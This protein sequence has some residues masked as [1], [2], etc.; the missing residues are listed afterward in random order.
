MTFTIVVFTLLVLI[1]PDLYTLKMIASVSRLNSNRRMKVIERTRSVLMNI[2]YYIPMFF[3]N[4]FILNIPC[5]RVRATQ[6]F[7]LF[8]R[9]LFIFF[10]NGIY[11][12]KLSFRCLAD[13]IQSH[14]IQKANRRTNHVPME[15]VFTSHC[16]V[17]RQIAWKRSSSLRMRNK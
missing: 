2:Q 9:L 15:P 7:A 1:K 17:G 4:T 3:L 5:I 12:K 13:L 16:A 14:F 11:L 8:W 10:N 6:P